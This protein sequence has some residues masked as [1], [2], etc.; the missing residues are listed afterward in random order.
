VRALCLS[1]DFPP[2]SRGGYELQC[3][4]FVEHLRHDGH[5]VRVITGRELPRFPV[6]PRPTSLPAARR[7]E[8]RAA[9]VLHRHLRGFRPDA[10]CLWRL[11]EL[12]V[13][14]VSRIVRAGVPA[15]GMVCDAW[16]VHGP[17]R[18]PWARHAGRPSFAGVRWLF[19]SHAL[20]RQVLAAGVDPGVS[21]VVPW[22][23]DL[24]ALPL[25]PERA[26]GRRLLYAG[27]LS[28]LKGVDL[29]VRALARLSDTSLEVI[30]EGEAD[31]VRDLHDLATRLGVRSRTLFR[32][33]LPP[34]EVAG[35]YARAD[36][37]LFP[38]RWDE[39]FG[40]IPLEAMA[41]GT[42]VIATATGGSAE[43]LLADRTAVVVPPED[44]DAIAAAVRRLAADPAL[45]ASLRAA[46]RRM[47]ERY[48][49]E[50]S[51]AR[52]V[53]A[54]EEAAGGRSPAT[55]SRKAD[56]RPT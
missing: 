34:A 54:L 24:A 42:P 45:R 16:M 32:G 29:A 43:F 20:R 19:V 39:P 12:S 9:R 41:R 35:A 15:I 50:R 52:V 5:E 30:G 47:A 17:R 31:Y 7:A 8:R 18:D 28:P 51:H 44:P 14:L 36:A 55:A 10:V 53:R 22:G 11:G 3:H 1:T 56:R 48:P 23:V 27:R 38:V 25:A 46:G 26:T 33:P 21:D 6:V 40:A 49:A 4:G 2:F 37:V 13:S